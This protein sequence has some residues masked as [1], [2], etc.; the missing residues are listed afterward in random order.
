[1]RVVTQVEGRSEPITS[2]PPDGFTWQ[3]IGEL[4]LPT[5][6]TGR[7][8]PTTVFPLPL[9]VGE[10]Q[11]LFRPSG[12]L[13]PDWQALETEVCISLSAEATPSLLWL[14][15]TQKC[16]H[17]R[18]RGAW[19]T[20]DHKWA[21]REEKNSNPVTEQK[22]MISLSRNTHEDDRTQAALFCSLSPK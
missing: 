3:R 12:G 20:V 15:T 9:A 5:H 8:G 14:R 2:P 7:P 22:K 13:Q 21:E 10:W 18:H 19:Q 16:E 11:L 17:N 6:T 1:M 4:K